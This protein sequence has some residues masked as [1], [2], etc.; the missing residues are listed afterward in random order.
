[1]QNKNGGIDDINTKTLKTLL[2]HLVD[3]LVHILYF[4]I[5]QASWPDALK[6]AEVIPIYKSKEK[7]IATN[8][9]PIFLISNLAKILEKII[10][11]RITN[12]K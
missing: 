12:N 8:Y 4:S 9:R 1:M 11:K 3:P 5:D 10:H 6:I 7:Y 2:E